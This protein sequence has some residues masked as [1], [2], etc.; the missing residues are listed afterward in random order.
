MDDLGAGWAKGSGLL[1]AGLPHVCVGTF[2][3]LTRGPASD[4]DF[5]VRRTPPLVST[6]LEYTKR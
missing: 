4:K 1:G 2:L 5:A 3:S 6:L